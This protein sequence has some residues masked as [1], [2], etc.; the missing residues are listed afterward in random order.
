MG[1]AES[2]VN[3]MSNDGERYL[4]I[5]LAFKEDHLPLDMLHAITAEFQHFCMT[6]FRV[7]EYAFYADDH[8]PR[9]RSEEHT[10]E[11]QSL[12]R[13]SYAVF[14]LNKKTTSPNTST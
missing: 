4:H 2:V 6:A 14:C 13:I 12:M 7:D 9:I 1:L 10:S 3:A 8:L 5:T 11:L